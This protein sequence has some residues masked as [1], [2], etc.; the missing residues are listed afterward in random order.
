MT[1][2]LKDIGPSEFSAK[3]GRERA[4]RPEPV[5]SP[6]ALV[7]AVCALALVGV[8]IYGAVRVLPGIGQRIGDSSYFRLEDVEVIGIVKT[9]RDEIG[10]AIGFAAGSPLLETDLAA[11]RE[12]VAAIDWVK[13]AEVSRDL[14]NK[15]IV[16][17]TEHTPV[18]VAM[19]EQGR[20]FVDPDGELARIEANIG[21][22]PTFIGMDCP[23]QYI[24]GTRLLTL[25]REER[26]VAEGHVKTV[27]FDSVMGYSV[28]TGEGIE[29]I[30][31]QPPFEKKLERLTRVL[32]DA[33]RRGPVRYVCLNIEDRVVVRLGSPVE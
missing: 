2:D 26:L 14:P 8:V 24:G 30:V 15:L 16:R 11:I 31:G 20:Q 9:D 17:I 27:K 3:G 23:D 5:R 29:I 1:R 6:A 12:R 18:A 22:L 4:G 28:I 13:E 32:P 7:V 25:I 33:Q 19:T 21:G 10:R